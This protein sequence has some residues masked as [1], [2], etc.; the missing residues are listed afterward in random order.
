MYG[1][2][3]EQKN[4][5]SRDLGEGYK[6]SFDKREII[7]LA[8]VF[9]GIGILINYFFGSIMI[10]ETQDYCISSGNA[11]QLELF[12]KP[13]VYPYNGTDMDYVLGEYITENENTSC[14][15]V[16]EFYTNTSFTNDWNEMYLVY[17]EIYEIDKV[18]KG[19]FMLPP[20]G[21]VADNSFDC[22]DFAHAS[23]CLAREYNFTCDIYY[24][25]N[26]GKTVPVYI[27]H[28]GACCETEEG[29]KCV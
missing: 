15:G 24:R 2:I 28:L 7:C 6:M 18:A 21:M 29:V 3:P 20:S 25:A 16:G 23:W 22:E 5:P 1:D 26:V 13:L 27:A 14:E 10:M 4:L 9:G 12:A 17:N 19:I 11:E 8:V